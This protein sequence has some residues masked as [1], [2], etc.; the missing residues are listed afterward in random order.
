M[1]F[2]DEL[3]Q[4]VAILEEGKVSDTLE[5]LQTWR[6]TILRN[7]SCKQAMSMAA[8]NLS[9]NCETGEKHF[10]WQWAWSNGEKRQ[11]GW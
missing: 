10:S 8:P 7:L 6:M 11:Q 4:A 5:V 2:I 9:M 3:H 1:K